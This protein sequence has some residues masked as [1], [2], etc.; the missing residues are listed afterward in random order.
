[1]TEADGTRGG[2]YTLGHSSHT[3]EAFLDLLRRHKIDVLVDTRSAPFSRFVPQFNKDNLRDA[4]LGEG[5]R[6][7]FYGRE[8]GGR[9]EGSEFYDAQGHVLYSA[10]SESPLFLDGLARVVRGA[11]TCRVALLCSEEDPNVCH[12]RLL[13]ARILHERGIMVRHIRG[14]GRV[15]AETELLEA[16]ARREAELQARADEARRAAE[17]RRQGGEAR[18]R[19]KRERRE[20][21]ARDSLRRKQ[22]AAAARLEKRRQSQTEAEFRRVER[23][24]RAEERQAQAA[25]RKRQAE[26]RRRQRAEGRPPAQ[27]TLF[28]MEE[29][30]AWRSSPSG[31]PAA[32][33]PASSGG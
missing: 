23:Q 19:E 3:Q 31:L 29:S 28:S 17:R 16:E 20:Q 7:G 18:R 22:E 30:E 32:P 10:I 1:M 4:V 24:R 14:D 9:P 2:I 25:A 5:V 8:L 12:R 15:Q 33:P 26:D 21:A 27:A 13:I 6:Y 11:E